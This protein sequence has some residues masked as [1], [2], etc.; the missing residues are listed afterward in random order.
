MN[1]ERLELGINDVGETEWD[2]F[3][4]ENPG[5]TF[6]HL[7]LWGKIIATTF[8]HG[9]YNLS[10]RRQG[11]LVGVFPLVLVRHGFLRKLL[12]SVAFGVYGGPVAAEEDSE[13]A[14]VRKAEDLCRELGAEYV[15][16]R[17]EREP[18]W[19][20]S[21][22]HTHDSFMVELPDSED[23]L[24]KSL[25]R[26]ARGAVRRGIKSGLRAAFERGRVEEFYAIYA[27]SV[28]N[29]G[30]PVF[31]RSLMKNLVLLGGEE[32]DI[33]CVFHGDQIVSAVMTFFFRDTVIPYYGGSLKKFLSLSPNSFMYWELM[34]R[35]IEAGYRKFDFGR[36]RRGSGS[37]QFKLN[38]GFEPHPVFNYY[39]LNKRNSIPNLST[40]NPKFDLPRRIW[41]LMPAFITDRLG[42]RIVKYIP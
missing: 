24:L 14:L 18:D 19:G 26:K 25:R 37:Y 34:R 38:W 42:P 20:W 32:V 17:V 28:R 8:G 21:K 3:V 35:S 22:A 27:A 16:A 2:S 31:P 30:S 12:V 4:R 33:L 41:S 1:S 9:I 29:L 6:F 39:Y 13:A 10:A 40:A 36:S 23:V 15:E 7:T 11:K 5:G